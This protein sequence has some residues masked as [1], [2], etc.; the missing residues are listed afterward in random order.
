[1]RSAS[2]W[3]EKTF[4]ATNGTLVAHQ[5]TTYRVADQR[6]AV[7]LLHD[8]FGQ[9]G[10]GGPL[11]NANA[12]AN[13]DEIGNA[14]DADARPLRN[15]EFVDRDD[16]RTDHRRRTTRPCSTMPCRQR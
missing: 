10:H 2:P 5:S 13:A 16:S 14:H 4:S 11:V 1:M 9:R 6:R 7:V 12:N 3:A 15:R 8:Q